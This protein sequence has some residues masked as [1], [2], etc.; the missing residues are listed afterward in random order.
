[1]PLLVAVGIIVVMAAIFAV[2]I[3]SA[4]RKRGLKETAKDHR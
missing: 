3:V 1:M 4:N 2:V